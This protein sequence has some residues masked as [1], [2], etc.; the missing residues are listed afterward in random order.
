MQIPAECHSD[1]HAIETQFDAPPWFNQATD[2]QI[3]RLAACGWGFDYPADE[4]AVFVGETNESVRH[5]F[6]Y[7]ELVR[8]KKDHPGFECSINASAA[9]AWIV[10]QRPELA[11]QIN[12][13]V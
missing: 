8:H 10:E 11:R 1:D 4:I 3:I 6:S 2:E 7:L 5:M 13:E 12:D 9:M